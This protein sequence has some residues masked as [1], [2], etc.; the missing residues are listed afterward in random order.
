MLLSNYQATEIMLGTV[1]FPILYF[2][3][4][5]LSNT[6]IIYWDILWC[7]ISI[8]IILLFRYFYINYY[9]LQSQNLS[10]NNIVNGIY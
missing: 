1:L 2:L 4:L 9:I 10:S 8:F 6:H 7:T 3:Y 5:Y